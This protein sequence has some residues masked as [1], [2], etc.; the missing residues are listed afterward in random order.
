MAPIDLS[1]RT[2]FDL[3]LSIRGVPASKSA[4]KT[5]HAMSITLAMIAIIARSRILISL[6]MNWL[7]LPQE[8]QEF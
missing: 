4:T 1:M 8:T 7:I 3:K 5:Y 2:A 6:F